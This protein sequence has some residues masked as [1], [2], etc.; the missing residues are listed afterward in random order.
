VACTLRQFSKLDAIEW[1]P[2]V[3]ETGLKRVYSI[4][5]GGTPNVIKANND[6]LALDLPFLLIV[7]VSLLMESLSSAVD[8]ASP[9]T[10]VSATLSSMPRRHRLTQL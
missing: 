8:L 9:M 6:R 5:W 4:R 2:S 7:A 1:L 3:Y 10:G